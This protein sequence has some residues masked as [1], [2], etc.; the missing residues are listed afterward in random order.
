MKT[1]LFILEDEELNSFFR[2]AKNKFLH[3][4]FYTEQRKKYTILLEKNGKPKGGK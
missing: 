4:T 1:P 3:N 2:S